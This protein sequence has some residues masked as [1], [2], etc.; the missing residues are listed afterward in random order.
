MGFPLPLLFGCLL[1]VS[2]TLDFIFRQRRENYGRGK[3]NRENFPGVVSRERR[4]SSPAS[5]SS[6]ERGNEVENIFQ[7]PIIDTPF[8]EEEDSFVPG[9]G[10][11]TLS[12]FNL[13][14]NTISVARNLLKIPYL[15]RYALVTCLCYVR[16]V[17]EEFLLK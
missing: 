12:K 13:S 5:V 16:Y 9:S 10:K 15:P 4:E 8:D 7:G 11:R 6:L 2:E 14:R 1:L 17:V 3:R